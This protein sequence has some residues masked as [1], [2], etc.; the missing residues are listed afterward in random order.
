VIAGVYHG[1]SGNGSC[2][3]GTMYA[4]RVNPHINWIVDT[5]GEENCAFADHY[6]RCWM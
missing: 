2:A 6:T 5:I 3:T 1:G 4:V